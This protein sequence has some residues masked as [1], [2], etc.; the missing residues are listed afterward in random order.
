MIKYVSNLHEINKFDNVIDVRSPSEFK[1]DHIP[2]AINLPVLTDD[3]RHLIGK[4]YTQISTFKAKTKGAALIARNI[5]DHISKE[6]DNKP[7]SWKPLV[8]CWRGG[9]RSKAMALIFKEIG[10]D[11]NILQGGYKAYRRFVRD[12]IA[13]ISS[14]VSLKVICGPTGSG[15]S[16]LLHSLRNINSQIIDLEQLANHRGSVLGWMPNTPQESQKMFETKVWETL[17]SFDLTQ[18]IFVESES[19][20]IGNLQIP[21]PLISRMWDSDCIV[22]EATLVS[23]VELLMNDY[24]HFL[25]APEKLITSLSPLVRTHGEKTVNSWVKLINQKKWDIFVEEILKTHYDPAY[26]RS[27]E[28]HYNRLS[29][30]SYHCINKFNKETL[31]TISIHISNEAQ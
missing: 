25:N 15:K 22:L 2:N 23:R 3:E 6:L 21:Q 13:E 29:S 10:W 19:K 5:A 30:A 27:I 16:L 31:S 11:V 8:Y 18:P 20:K 1:L 14:K 17:S 28:G 7:K 4:T 24:K 9:K 12:Q 26:K